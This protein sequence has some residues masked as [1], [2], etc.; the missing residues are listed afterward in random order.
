[1]IN[2]GIIGPVNI[3]TTNRA[4]GVWDSAEQFYA[5]RNNLWPIS[6]DIVRDGLIVY[7]DTA[8]IL[9]YPGS[10]STINNLIGGAPIGTL[11]GSFTWN[12]VARTMKLNNTSSTAISNISHLQLN[13]VS[14]I[15][16]V[17]TWYFI[18][19]NPALNSYLYDARNGFADGYVWQGQV[20]PTW[21]QSSL[22]GASR[23]TSNTTDIFNTLSTWRNVTLYNSAAGT[24]DI[25]FF[26]RFSNNEGM[27]ASFGVILIYNKVLTDLENLQ[28]FNFFRSRFGI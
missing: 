10:G 3:P 23:V 28:N 17:S 6:Q 20:G 15:R 9:S 27:D 14:N 12:S 26:A 24:D 11:S 13:S 16:T 21:T 25:T 8:D 4:S 7:I 5:R 18:H 22:N 2:G 19:S 1:M